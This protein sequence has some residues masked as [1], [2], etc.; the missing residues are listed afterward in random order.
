MN[1]LSQTRKLNPNLT[2]PKGMQDAIVGTATKGKTP[3]VVVSTTKCIHILNRREKK[4]TPEQAEEWFDL[5][6]AAANNDVNG[7]YFVD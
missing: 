1:Y 5:N 7:P 6:V 2:F 4:L 3:V